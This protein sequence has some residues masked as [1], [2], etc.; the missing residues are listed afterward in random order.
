MKIEGGDVFFDK[1]MITGMKKEEQNMTTEKRASTL[2][3]LSTRKQES[4][5]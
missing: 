3:T 1:K 2:E 4:F 5:L